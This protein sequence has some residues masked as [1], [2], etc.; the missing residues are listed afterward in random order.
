MKNVLLREQL[1]IGAKVVL[2]GVNYVVKAKAPI[3]FICVPSKGKRWFELGNAVCIGKKYEDVLMED[4]GGGTV[5]D[6]LREFANSV[7]YENEKA[8][9]NL[10]FV[11]LA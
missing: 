7:K 10:F 2:N 9:L 11:T 5:D 3:K 6:V 4:L 8:I 1:P